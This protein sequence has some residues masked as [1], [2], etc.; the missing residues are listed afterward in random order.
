MQLNI[1]EILEMWKKDS[2]IDDLNLDETSKNSARLHAKYL[3]FMAVAKLQVKKRQQ[4]LAILQRDKWLWMSGKMDKAE[5]DKRGWPY[6]PFNGLKI[7]KSDMDL[8]YDADPDLQ[9]AKEKIVYLETV[10]DT[11]KEI[12]DNI[13]WRHSNIKNIIE[14]KKFTSGV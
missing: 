1:E 6:D 8:Y 11:L 14:W 9:R 2:V 5:M 12:I 4:D 10:V 13:K 3:E 7:M